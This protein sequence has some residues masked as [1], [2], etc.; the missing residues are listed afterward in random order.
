MPIEPHAVVSAIRSV[1]GDT[2][3]VPL[4][5]PDIGVLERR[6]VN[7]CLDSTFVSSVGAFVDRFEQEVAARTGATYAVAVSNGTVALQIALEL[8]GVRPGDEVVVP[9]LSF[10]A[11]ANAVAHVGAHPVFVDS[12]PETLGMSPTAV[13]DLLAGAQRADGSVVNPVTGRRIAVIVP[14]HTLGHPMQITELVAVADEHGI[15]VVEDAA[16]S[17]GS[18]VG[19]RHTG[20]FGRLGVL[21][22]NGNKIVTTGG[23]GMILTDDAELGRRAKHLTTTAKLPHAW[24]YEFDEIGYNYRLPNLNAALGVAQIERLDEFLSNKRLVAERYAVAFEELGGVEFLAEPTGTLSNYWLCAI[25]IEG[26]LVERDAILQ[27]AYDDGLQCRPFWN[28]LHRQAPY[29]EAPTG[30]LPMATV[31]HASV[32]CIPSSAALAAV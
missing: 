13:A 22:F 8:A 2:P 24:E 10:I 31:L 19:D 15:P 21:S 1:V 27:A 11:T 4:H 30:P 16:E 29:R 14:M 20:T 25:R 6:Y 5:A 18:Y 3:H 23:G 28:L 12:D 9:A 32:V 26:G 17:L 7:E